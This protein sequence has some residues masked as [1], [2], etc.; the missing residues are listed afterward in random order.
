MAAKLLNQFRVLCTR[1]HQPL[2]HKFP[3][4]NGSSL[5]L[6]RAFSQV[7]LESVPAANS[8]SSVVSE[9]PVSSHGQTK[10]NDNLNKVSTISSLNKVELAKFSAIAETWW[11]AEGPFKPLHKMNPTRL[12]FIRSTLCRQFRKD[13]TSARPFEGV[14]IVDVGCGGGILSEVYTSNLFHAS[15]T[16]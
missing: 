10:S 15:D 9:R 7:S 13:P 4:D 2:R 6:H 16:N 5:A 14:K 8:S 12:A 1:N 11:D 3:Y